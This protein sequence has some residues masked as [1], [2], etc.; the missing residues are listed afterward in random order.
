M[1]YVEP[2][3]RAG[4]TRGPSAWVRRTAVSVVRGASPPGPQSA[5]PAP[6]AHTYKTPASARGPSPRARPRPR[7]GGGGGAGISGPLPPALPSPRPR[8][9]RP[10][11]PGG[12]EGA[13]SWRCPG[14][15]LD[16][17]GWGAARRQVEVQAR[18]QV[19]ARL[20]CGGVGSG[21]GSSGLIPHSEAPAGRTVPG[22]VTRPDPAPGRRSPRAA[23][24][25]EEE[26]WGGGG[27]EEVVGEG[28]W[29][30]QG[31]IPGLSALL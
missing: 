14:R 30:L 9:R 10:P 11:G 29:G 15:G 2:A 1:S 25:G 20:G 13:S 16:L 8:Q 6:R 4:G 19:A 24:Q 7:L 5:F 12:G 21:R 31:R 18:S 23:G 28:L 17:T 3:A 26:E 27:G 22:R